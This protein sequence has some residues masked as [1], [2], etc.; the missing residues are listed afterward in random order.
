MVYFSTEIPIL[1]IIRRAL[2]KNVGIFHNHFEYFTAIWYILR[3]FCI[4][5]GI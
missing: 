4:F 5:Y 1:G 2:D 3:S